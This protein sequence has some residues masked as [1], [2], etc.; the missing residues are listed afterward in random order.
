MPDRPLA[1]PPQP[2]SFV[3][4]RAELAELA[5]LLA[6][7]DCRLLTI[8]GPGGIGKTRL[9]LEAAAA[10]HDAFDDG[11]AFVSLQ[12][13]TSGDEL[14][15]AFAAAIGCTLAGREDAREQ[16][17]RFLRPKRLL[18]I[19]DNLEHLL[20]EAPWL[21]DLLLAAP[22]LRLVVT[23][24]EALNLREEWRYPLTGLALPV[25]GDDDPAPSEAVLLFVERARRVRRDFSLATERAGVARLCRIAEG[26]PL[27]LELAAAWTKTLPCDT[28][29]AEIERN[30]AFLATDLRNVAPRHRSVQAAFDHSWA[31][32]SEDERRVFRRLAVFRGGFRREAAERIAG[33]TLPTL[34]TLLDK[35]L[36]R[37]ESDGRHHLHE[38]LRQYA[39]GHLRA[40]PDEAAAMAQ[41]HRRYYLHFLADRVDAMGGRGQRAATDAIDEEIG[42]IRAAWAD[43]AGWDDAETLRGAAHTLAL[44]AIFRGP[45]QEGVALLEHAIRH[46]HSATPSAD[47][48]LALTALLVD[49]SRLQMRLGRTPQAKAALAEALARYD[50]LPAVPSPKRAIDPRLG[51]AGVAMVEGDYAE[52]TRLAE[53]A[54]TLAEAQ[55]PPQHLSGP[56]YVLANVALAHG[57]Y[58]AAQEATNRAYE[59]AIEAEEYWFQGYCLNQMG[60]IALALGEHA[61][62][63]RHFEASYALREELGDPEGMALALANLGKVALLGGDHAAARDQYGRSRDGYREIGDRGGLAQALHGLAQVALAEGDERA[64]SDDLAAALGVATEIAF[65]PLTLAIL[66]TCG[67]LLARHDGASLGAALLAT[68]ER[69]AA[70]DG[71]TRHRARLARE[72]YGQAADPGDLEQLV[73]AAREALA[74]LAAGRTAAATP[75]PASP[76]EPVSPLSEPLTTREQAVLGLLAAGHSNQEIADQL[77][78]SLGTV[79]WYTGQI[80]GKLQ[81][82]SR[83][84]AIARARELRLVP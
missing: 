53:I 14:A 82:R 73:A 71:E 64:A 75:P 61:A 23:S 29:A 62:A 8:V 33:A 10:T 63:R 40:A 30:I 60:H 81:T 83:T 37:Y 78:L 48:E 13:I 6:K 26:L 22:G 17:T 68:A 31:L 58:A 76:L 39:E 28:I 74:A 27:A 32:L 80:Y 66:G 42:N 36:L 45:Y 11:V 57:D 77:F 3:G 47:T 20:A 84:H 50:T 72:R 5:D 2:T 65:V 34:A 35:S 55:P 24:R 19:L 9:A 16:V 1:L 46:L 49:L 41:A 38:L 51:L 44:H 70:S 4:R 43:L 18:L 59:A 21:G 54:R 52:A 7:P 12:A 25:E 67:D 15:P 69:H 56:W 79:K